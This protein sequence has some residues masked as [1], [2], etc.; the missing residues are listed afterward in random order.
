MA[1]L[2]LVKHS[3]LSSMIFSTTSCWLRRTLTIID[4]VQRESDICRGERETLTLCRRFCARQG[5]IS[6]P[7]S[8][9]T[10]PFQTTQ[11]HSQVSVPA[12]WGFTGLIC[13]S[14]LWAFLKCLCWLRW[15]HSQVSFPWICGFTGLLHSWLCYALSS[16]PQFLGVSFSRKFCWLHV[17]AWPS[18]MSFKETPQQIIMCAF[19]RYLNKTAICTFFQV[20][21]KLVLQFCHTININGSFYV[22]KDAG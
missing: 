12:I 13:R 1:M 11:R 15:T 6:R 18:Y 20:F 17:E 9:F 3:Q 16:S 2:C 10:H 5:N 7:L 14:E 19:L 4:V 22:K 21:D 8:K